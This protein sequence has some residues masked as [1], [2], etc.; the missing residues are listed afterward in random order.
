[1]TPKTDLITEDEQKKIE[2]VLKSLQGLP[3]TRTWN[4]QHGKF[5]LGFRDATLRNKTYAQETLRQVTWQSLG[6][7]LGIAFG[8]KPDKWILQLEHLLFW[9]LLNKWLIE[10]R[11]GP[12]RNQTKLDKEDQS[13]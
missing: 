3:D 12:T 5:G 10:N 9:P 13:H 1:M 4:I 7:R 8:K 2:C 11:G 6:Y